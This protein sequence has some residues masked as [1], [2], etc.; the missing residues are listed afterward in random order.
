MVK[1]I[2]VFDLILKFLLLINDYYKTEME[3]KIN[4]TS[5]LEETKKLIK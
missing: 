5:F 1:T 4:I 3:S 2:K